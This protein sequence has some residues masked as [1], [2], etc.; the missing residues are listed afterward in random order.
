MTQ[1]ERPQH[2]Q[3]QHHHHLGP[4][5]SQALAR[6]ARA[7][8]REALGGPRAK[9]PAGSWGETRGAAYV[10]LRWPG[11]RLHGCI[12]SIEARRAL[13]DDVADN[14]VASALYDPRA[15]PLTLERADAL[16]VEVSVLTPLEPVAFTDEASAL[17]ALRP[18]Q[19]GVVLRWR[20]RRATFLP[21]VWASLPEPSD[22]LGELKEK[23][24]L[25]RAFWAPDVELFRYGVHKCT[26]DGAATATASRGGSD[27]AGAA[28]ESGDGEGGAQA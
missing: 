21:Q 11:G 20:T 2:E 28:Q 1:P 16:R 8:I 3:A 12:G 27:A 5:E 4:A 6:Y 22:F 17:A 15:M 24:G 25:P 23:A 9:R 13:L 10:T 26:D 7:A 19:D 18:G 14:A